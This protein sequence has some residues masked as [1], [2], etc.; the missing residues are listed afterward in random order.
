MY[1][2]KIGG[3]GNLLVGEGD[4]FASPCASAGPHAMFGA[5]CG[6]TACPWPIA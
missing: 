5:M 2:Y 1:E 3:Q 6:W 4:L